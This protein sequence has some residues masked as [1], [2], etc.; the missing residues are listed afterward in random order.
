MAALKCSALEAPPGKARGEEQN[1]QNVIHHSARRKPEK[2]GKEKTEYRRR[3]KV[4]IEMNKHE[5]ER[6]RYEERERWEKKN[7]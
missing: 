1:K 7:E 2:M 6:K 5:P 4:K 3:A